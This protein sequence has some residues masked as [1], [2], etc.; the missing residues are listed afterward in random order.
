MNALE[1]G[2]TNPVA[3]PKML[4]ALAVAGGPAV[5]DEPASDAAAPARVKAAGNF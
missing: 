2:S 4:E 3:N 5:T 1:R